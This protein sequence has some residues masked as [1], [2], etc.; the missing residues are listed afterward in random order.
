M[1][2]TRYGDFHL[3]FSFADKIISINPP[4]KN[5]QKFKTK[6]SANV[7]LSSLPHQNFNGFDQAKFSGKTPF[8]IKGAGE[9][10]I[11]DIFVKGYGIKSNFEGEEKII[12]SYTVLLDNIHFA[13]FGPINSGEKFSNDAFE[14]FSNCEVFILPIG[15]GDSFSPKDAYKFVKQFSP[16]IIIPV[17]YDQQA[18]LEEF[19]KEFSLDLQ[20]TDK[21]TLKSK[22]ISDEEI[23]IFDLSLS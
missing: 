12:N 18:D 19:S 14:E 8:V 2:I 17:F 1:I 13:I 3:K 16:S 5:S 7:V 23:K 21:L 11:S 15:G 9:Y 4:Q 6:F 22:D 10:E 20:K